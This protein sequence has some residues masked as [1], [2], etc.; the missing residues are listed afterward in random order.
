MAFPDGE[1]RFRFPDIDSITGKSGAP[2]FNHDSAGA[3]SLANQFIAL[4][5]TAS[6]FIWRLDDFRFQAILDNK[7]P[8]SRMVFS[9]SSED[10]LVGSKEGSENGGQTLLWKLSTH[11]IVHVSPSF[12][13]HRAVQSVAFSPDDRVLLIVHD[14]LKIRAW[15][16]RTG[17]VLTEHSGR[18]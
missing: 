13:N 8:I 16:A 14:D 17:D 7:Q 3:F 1:V 5:S 10:L 15:D 12:S 11:Q 18:P 2:T 9:K 4:A 6:I